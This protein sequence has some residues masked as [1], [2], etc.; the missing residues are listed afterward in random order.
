MIASQRTLGA[1]GEVGADAVEQQAVVRV[2]EGD[3][4]RGGGRNANR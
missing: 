1:E 3:V 4:Q 2:G